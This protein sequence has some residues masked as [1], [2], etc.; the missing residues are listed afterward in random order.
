M[1]KGKLLKG[2][3]ILTIVGVITRA[4]GFYYKIFLS[5]ALGTENLAVFPFC[6]ITSCINGYYYYLYFV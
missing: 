4:L 2:T 3:A 6:G 1:S 5:N